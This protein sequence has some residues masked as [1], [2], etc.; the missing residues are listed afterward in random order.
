MLKTEII[1]LAVAISWFL[2]SERPEINEQNSDN[3]VTSDDGE[4]INQDT[5]DAA[6]HD[7]LEPETTSDT[8][9]GGWVRLGAI[10]ALAAIVLA[11]I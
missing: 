11:V 8:R 7:P 4:A 1:F 3:T 6:E 9:A 10:T 2:C 5:N